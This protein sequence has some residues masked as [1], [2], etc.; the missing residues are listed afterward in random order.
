MTMRTWDN[1]FWWLEMDPTSF[2]PRTV[3]EPSDW[4]TKG[5]ARPLVIEA[6]IKGNN[7]HTSVG[8]ATIWLSPELVDFDKPIKISLKGRNISPNDKQL[9]PSLEVLLEDVRTR[10]DRLHPFWARV[11]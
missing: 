3:V 1:Y 11:D 2:P 4:S 6:S 7:I 10:G 8:K 9:D 5:T